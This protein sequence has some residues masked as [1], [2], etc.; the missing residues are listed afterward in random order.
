MPSVGGSS[1]NFGGF[2]NTGGG[3]SSGIDINK[4]LG[5][6]GGANYA[7][8]S[9]GIN[10]PSHGYQTSV[11]GK[12]GVTG[13][14]GSPAVNNGG[15]GGGGNVVPPPGSGVNSNYQAQQNPLYQ[16]MMDILKQQMS[17]AQGLY[18]KAPDFSGQRANINKMQ[19]IAANEAAQRAAAG[20]RGGMTTAMQQ[21][22][23]M[24]NNQAMTGAARDW[25]NEALKHQEN[26][27]NSMNNIA[28]IMS[29][30]TNN[31]ASN[32]LGQLAEQRAQNQLGLEGW[33]TQ[34]QLELE[35]YKAQTGGAASLLSA[36][37]PWAARSG[38]ADRYA[39]V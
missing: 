20:G 12:A 30:N 13:G 9:A 2:R 21:Q 11:G 14:M 22:T 32:Q 16:Q 25:G 8:G 6:G 35:K 39:L 36:L 4:I 19:S 18:D 33:K 24:G 1:G 28:G 34:Q 27:L 38:A 26:V 29:G 31:S 23:L 37:Y 3:S 15:G 17:Q 10:A 7:P 5:L